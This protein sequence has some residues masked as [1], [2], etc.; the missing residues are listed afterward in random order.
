[1]QVSILS[2]NS[3]SRY[4]TPVNQNWADLL[5]FLQPHI[6]RQTHRD[7]DGLANRQQGQGAAGQ[8][9]FDV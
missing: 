9:L 5:S 2:A 7:M 1:M 6:N 3:N 4:V 8:S